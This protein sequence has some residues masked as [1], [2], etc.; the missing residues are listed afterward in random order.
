MKQQLET[1]L[2]IQPKRGPR[3]KLWHCDA[4]RMTADVQIWR[5]RHE[6]PRGKCLKW[7]TAKGDY[8]GKPCKKQRC[9]EHDEIKVAR[10]DFK[11][12][13]YFG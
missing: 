9:A 6:P 2:Q 5:K 4:D 7:D 1:Y 11:Q 10:N 12:Y 3:K 8:C 13:K